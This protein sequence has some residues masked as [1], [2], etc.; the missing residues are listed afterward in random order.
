MVIL[1]L[2]V[3]LYYNLLQKL[4]IFIE[5]IRFKESEK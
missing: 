2:Y 3:A 4:L 1:A 5:N